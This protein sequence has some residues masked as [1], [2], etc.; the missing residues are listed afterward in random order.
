M[1]VLRGAISR[2]TCGVGGDTDRSYRMDGTRTSNDG[3]KA[4]TETAGC[5]WTWKKG[6]SVRIP[7]ATHGISSQRSIPPHR[8][9]PR[10]QMAPCAAFHSPFK[11]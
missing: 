7:G 8:M 9:H 4:T 6:L 5:S 11:V 10:A 2:T 1:L 3:T